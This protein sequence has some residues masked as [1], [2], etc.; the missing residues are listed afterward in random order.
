MGGM[1]WYLVKTPHSRYILMCL[2]GFGKFHVFDPF[3]AWYRRS[4]VVQNGKTSRFRP[5]FL[6]FSLV[7]RPFM[8]G[9]TWYLVVRSHTRYILMCLKGFGKLHVF[10]RFCAWYRRSGVV[11]SGKNC[12]F[13]VCFLRFSLV[14]RPFMGGMTWYLV[15][16]SHT[17][18]ILMCLKGFWKI[19]RFRPFL[20][21]V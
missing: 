3:C 2:K 6:R 4:G 19:A 12:T 17:R 14:S 18:Y 11:H 13:S 10:D 1:T 5:F 15:V 16:R 7:S 8:G 21:V 9:M 20:R